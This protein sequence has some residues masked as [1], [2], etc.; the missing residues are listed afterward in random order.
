LLST[1]RPLRFFAPAAFLSADCFARF[2]FKT[3]AV[4]NS[5]NNS[6]LAR[7]LSDPS[8]VAHSITIRIEGLG[9]S[10]RRSL[11]SD[12]PPGRGEIVGTELGRSHDV[13]KISFTGSVTVGQGIMRLR[14]P[15]FPEGFKCRNSRG[16]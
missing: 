16:C 1:D 6:D 7:W 5:S 11:P 15:I 3:T 12:L 8:V 10:A 14:K 2:M 13:D 4:G 9:G